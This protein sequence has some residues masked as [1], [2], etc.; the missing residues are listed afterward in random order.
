M[1]GVLF[2]NRFA[3]ICNLCF[4]S[5]FILKDIKG[6]ENY[7]HTM[8]TILV[9]AV[10]AFIINIVTIAISFILYFLKS[11]HPFPKYLFFINIVFF[12]MQYYYFIISICFT[13]EHITFEERRAGVA[14]RDDDFDERLVLAAVDAVVRWRRR[15]DE[16]P[17]LSFV[18]LFSFSFE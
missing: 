15:L 7:H 4:L 14:H 18:C 17:L 12:I 10:I 6:L 11:K 8:S 3:L 9:L 16:I 13:N 5:M 2:M 1:R